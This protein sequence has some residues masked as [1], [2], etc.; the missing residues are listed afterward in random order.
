MWS[1]NPFSVVSYG[2]WVLGFSK[3]LLDSVVNWGEGPVTPSLGLVITWASS[4]SCWFFYKR[5]L[6]KEGYDYDKWFSWIQRHTESQYGRVPS[7]G[8]PVSVELE[9]WSMDLLTN[10]ENLSSSGIFINDYHIGTIT[11]NSRSRSSFCPLTV[12]MWFLAWS[13]CDSTGVYQELPHCNRGCSWKLPRNIWDPCQELRSKTNMLEW[14][15]LLASQGLGSL[16]DFR[17][18]EKEARIS[19]YRAISNQVLLIQQVLI[20]HL[21]YVRCWSKHWDSSSEKSSS[22]PLREEDGYWLGKRVEHST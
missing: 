10:L 14:T 17:D 19:Y 1:P 21:L 5:W 9:S 11:R 7:P 6:I 22:L 8:A 13:F 16:K 2:W 20:E 12:G 4:H 3:L 18:S 15:M